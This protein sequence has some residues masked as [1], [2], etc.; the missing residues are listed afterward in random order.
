MIST[1]NKQKMTISQLHRK[2]WNFD[3]FEGTKIAEI[4]QIF[5]LFKLQV[6]A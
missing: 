4:W 1:F 2:V 3:K 6:P 5:N